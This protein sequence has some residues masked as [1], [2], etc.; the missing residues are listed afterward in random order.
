MGNEDNKGMFYF[1]VQ[2]IVY[3][4]V[5]WIQNVSIKVNIFISSLFLKMV[6]SKNK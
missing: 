5:Y 1:I 2:Y 6:L 4:I 3:F